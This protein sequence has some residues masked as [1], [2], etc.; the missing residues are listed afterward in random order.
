MLAPLPFVFEPNNGTEILLC[1]AMSDMLL[2]PFDTCESVNSE[3]IQ[4]FE[5]NP[6]NS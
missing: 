6:K 4:K 1:D 5:M 2:Q 3:M